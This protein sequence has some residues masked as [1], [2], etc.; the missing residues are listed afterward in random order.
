MKLLRSL[1][2]LS[3]IATCPSALLQAETLFDAALPELG[4][5]AKGSKAKFNKDWPAQNA[6]SADKRTG[7]IFDPI[8][9][10]VIDIRLVMPVEIKAIDIAAFNYRNNRTANGVTVYFEGKQVAESDL[11]DEPGKV[12]RIP[13][14]GKGQHVQLV[15][16]GAHPVRKDAKTG[17][18]GPN[19]G[20]IGK[21]A[22]MTSTDLSQELKH[23]DNYQVET[24]PAFIASTTQSAEK[25]KVEVFGQPRKATSHPKTLWDQ[26]DVDHFKA[27]LKTSPEL[28]RQYADLKKAMDSLLLTEV[29]VPQP[30]KDDEGKWTH[31]PEKQVGKI[32]NELSL[33]ISNL[34]TIYA[35][36]GEEKYADYAKQLLLA[37]AEAFEGYAPGNR[38]GFTHDQG[39]LFDQRLS[40]A[41]WLI[42]VARGYDLIYNS[43][44]ITPEERANIQDNL[45]KASAK[46]IAA[47]SSTMR[48]PTNWSAICTTAVLITG[49]ATD[50]QDLVN[51]A[52]YGPG[53]TADN[54]KG[55]VMLHFGD[56]AINSD[57]LWA[58]G[59]I[60][61]QFMAMQALTADAEIL[62]RNGMD[63][64][65]HRDGAMKKLFDSPIAYSFPDLKTPSVHDTN[66]TNI[67]G[68]E[69]YLYEYGYLRY[70]DPRYL[71][72]LNNPTVSTRLDT[73]FQQFPISVL[74]DRDKNEKA[75]PIEWLS[76]NFIDVGYGILRNT[77]ANG[78]VS[79]LMDYGPNRSH[80]HPDKLN[81]DLWTTKTG[82]LIPDLGMVWYEQP[83][84]KNWYHT[85]LAHNTLTVDE[86]VQ[87]MSDGKL[88]VYGYTDS[89]GIQRG[90]A[91]QAAPGITMDRAVFLTPE[92][93]ADIFG[94][95]TRLP[96][97]LDLAWHIRGAFST[98]L[99]LQPFTFP[100]PRERGYSE[101][102]NTT[103]TKTDKAWSATYAIEGQKI[104]FHAAPG[105]ETEVITGDGWYGRERPRSIIQRRQ[106]NETLYGNAVDISCTTE[107]FVK[108]V[109][110]EGSLAKG[111][112]LLTV[113][114]AKGKDLCF[115]S[116]RPAS[117]QAGGLE[118]D[119]LQAF[120]RSDKDGIT[121]LFLGG[122]KN[123]KSG[124][125]QMTLAP[126]STVAL[127]KA[128][129][130]AYILS[131][132]STTETRVTLAFPAIAGMEMHQ[133][134]AK[135][136]RTGS[137]SKPGTSITLAG[138]SK[139]EFSP[140]GKSSVYDTR[141][142]MLQK[143][144]QEQEAAM[145]AELEAAT[146]RSK[147]RDEEV[148]TKAAPANTFVFVQAEAFKAEGDGKAN[149]ATNKTGHLGS[150]L[151][152]WN[153]EG[154]WFEWEIDLPAEG[155][156]HL[157]LCYCTEDNNSQR[158]IQV[159]GEVQEPY[160]PF[161]LPATGGFSNGSDDWKLFTAQ[162][163][164]NSKPLLVKFKQGKNVLRLTN[165]NGAAANIDYVVVSSPDVKVTRD[166]AAQQSTKTQ[167]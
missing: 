85:S 116:Y 72:I 16:K 99:P 149:L 122:G 23:V 161:S 115:A 107:G 51:L 57:G 37:Y 47:N 140:P 87:I 144:Q 134:D 68:R 39:R 118:T 95:F 75:P 63:M 70:K 10:G 135:G 86:Q 9:G 153:G 80:G 43:K 156:Y 20:G 12:T 126:A 73:R 114:T 41:T 138:G 158:E 25:P 162:D 106:S 92:Y 98:D 94:A 61:Y 19:W 54:P 120:V 119:G 64:Y 166:Q 163:P 123:L 96:R 128:D 83:L 91:L 160:A 15:F 108:N 121:G 105:I 7:S 31:L 137:P 62:W 127:E 67:V 2:L 45:L 26:Q 104:R 8:E 59:A 78:T 147:K 40:D 69:S 132:L 14:V 141:A 167:P 35:L 1:L 101:L 29:S 36:S 32:H 28:A 53:G 66:S 4:A 21:I 17:K 131:N 117:Y 110:L 52:L 56:K 93:L 102:A 33:H 165:L 150:S 76:E 125:A 143:R 46:F 109:A 130:G 79:L 100:E 42:P 3:L 152:G 145:K 49:F 113:E 148:A 124:P 38:P 142:A 112:G 133:V 77:T 97:K 13:A 155:Y 60:G 11:P 34:G 139:V 22:V 50:D 151:S 159:N 48:A 71:L 82:R 154:H 84:Y 164:V 129:T 88:L 65:R 89:M 74:Y 146:L 103:S 58:E 136:Q 157:T 18:E 27:M 24:S 5:T 6:L 55:G 30:V 111:Y 44:G 90:N 81:I